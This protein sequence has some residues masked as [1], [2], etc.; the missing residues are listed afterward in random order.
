MKTRIY[1]LFPPDK[2][3]ELPSWQFVLHFKA[4]FFG[5]GRKTKLAVEALKKIELKAAHFAVDL[6]SLSIDPHSNVLSVP[7]E[8]SEER[9]SEANGLEDYESD[10]WK[11]YGN[12]VE[13]GFG[14][15]YYEAVDWAEE[16]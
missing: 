14:D 16:E 3:H 6:E 15:L 10:V 12:V 5:R 2:I 11:I 8:V 13:Y 1:H 7:I 4:P 9:R